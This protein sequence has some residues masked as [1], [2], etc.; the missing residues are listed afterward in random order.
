MTTNTE[1]PLTQNMRPDG[2]FLDLRAYEQAGGYQAIRKVLN[3]G[4][5]PKAV[6]D[7]VKDANLRGRGGAGFQTGLKWSFVPLGKDAPNPTY[8]VVNADEMEPGTFK[9]RMLLERDPHQLIEGV[10][11][12][13]F[14][15]EADIA[16]I[17]LRGEYTLAAERLTRA[18]AEAYERNYLG[19]D[20]LGSGYSLEFHLHLSGGRY[21]CGD[22]TGLLNALEGKRGNPRSK[23][24]FPVVSG[25]FGKP[26]VVNNV[27]TLSCV[28]H[29]INN[30]AAWFRGLG[31]GKDGGTK[32]FGASGRVKRPGLWELPMGTTV[33]EILEEHAGGM[34]D[35][36]NFRGLLPG[37]ASTDFL[38]EEHLDVKMDFSEVQKA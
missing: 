19:K 7:E 5:E 20:I 6:T 1:T 38:T 30:G 27:E 12:A 2:S 34:R 13:G 16:Y 22:E 37:G 35:G 23:P 8:L 11:V 15:I 29:I 3:G 26:T 4:M 36:L 21:I 18:I 25:L 32:L 9:D 10:I 33:R 14:A 31:R 17:F 24:P 28:P